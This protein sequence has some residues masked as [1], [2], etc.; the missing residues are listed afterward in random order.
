MTGTFIVPSP[1]VPDDGGSGQYSAA[2]WVWIDGDT[3]TSAIL[4]TGV[5]FTVSDDGTTSYDGTT[6]SVISVRTS[7]DIA[8]N[9]M[10]IA[11]YEWFPD[12][13]YDF[14]GIQ[15]SAGDSV[16]VTVTAASA[17]SGTAVI[18]NITNGQKVSQS[19]TSSSPLCQTNAEWIVEDFDEGGFPVPLAN[20]GTVTFT[21]AQATAEQGDSVGPDGATIFTMVTESGDG[22][23]AEV[24]SSSVTVTYQG[25]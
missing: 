4:Q 9:D 15:F 19:I 6:P 21:G 1:S 12:P 20:F 25:Q 10:T 18:E 5:D 7:A 8:F 14:T 13:S 17:T 3:C 22:A 24:D 11:W 16:T 2:A 23:T